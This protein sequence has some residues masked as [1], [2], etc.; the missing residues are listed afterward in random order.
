M[1]ECFKHCVY[2]IVQLGPLPHTWQIRSNI[3][4]N[5]LNPTDAFTFDRVSIEV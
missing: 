5:D 1:L 3:I 2:A 4:E